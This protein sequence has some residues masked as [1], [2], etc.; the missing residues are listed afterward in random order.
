MAKLTETVWTTMNVLKCFVQFLKKIV[1]YI[2]YVILLFIAKITTV[3]INNFTPK[4]FG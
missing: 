1:D 2:E 4:Q 3:N